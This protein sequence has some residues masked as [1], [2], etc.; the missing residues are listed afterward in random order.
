MFENPVA[1]CR[2]E[3]LAKAE[4]ETKPKPQKNRCSG[5]PTEWLRYL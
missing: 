5:L 3:A 2:A 4:A 1:A